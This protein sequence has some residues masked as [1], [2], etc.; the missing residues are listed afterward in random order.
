MCVCVC[1]C[2]FIYVIKHHTP[3]NPPEGKPVAYNFCQNIP[4]KAYSILQTL[5]LCPNKF[6]EENVHSK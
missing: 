4:I 5:A 1:M 3:F 6:V 2:V